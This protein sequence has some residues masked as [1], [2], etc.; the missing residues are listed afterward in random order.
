MHDDGENFLARWSRRKRTQVDKPQ[1]VDEASLSLGE[2]GAAQTAEKSVEIANLAEPGAAHQVDGTHALS[3][4]AADETAP[5]SAT[6]AKNIELAK[7]DF[8]ALDFQSDYHQFMDGDVNDDLRNKALRKLWV[9]NPVLANIDGL[10][11][12][13]EDYTDAAVCLPKGVMKTA[14]QF[15]RGFL[16]DDEVAAWEALGKPEEPAEA[17]GANDADEATPDADIAEPAVADAQAHTDPETAV[18]SADPELADVA[19]SPANSP[20]IDPL[21]SAPE[22]TRSA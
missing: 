18:A 8:E 3:A 1:A 21:L 5:T 12:Y 2:Q 4:D 11:D 15:G 6:E 20:E 19:A 9:S 16:D 7:T 13:C 14:Y 17:E 10:D 22:T